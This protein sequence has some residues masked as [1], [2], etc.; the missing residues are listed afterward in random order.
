LVIK[1]SNHILTTLGEYFDSIYRTYTEVHVNKE[2]NKIRLENDN[3]Y[4]I[5][6]YDEALLDWCKNQGMEIIYED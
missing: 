5:V 2:G 6:P 1:G 3:W 4:S